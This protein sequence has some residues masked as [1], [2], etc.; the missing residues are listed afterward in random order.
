MTRRKH[1]RYPQELHAAR[2]LIEEAVGRAVRA[3]AFSDSAP[4][5]AEA[6]AWATQVGEMIVPTQRHGVNL[7]R[8]SPSTLAALLPVGN[9]SIEIRSIDPDSSEAGRPN[10]RQIA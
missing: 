6:V 1:P 7:F 3:P 5:D 2:L 4:G 8:A 10:G 9:R